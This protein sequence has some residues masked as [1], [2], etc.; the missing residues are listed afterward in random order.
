MEAGIAALPT[1]DLLCFV[2]FGVDVLLISV[3]AIEAVA[4]VVDFLLDSG[5]S[6]TA[7]GS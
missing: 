5:V 4:A 6:S 1:S 7:G 2:A 3:I